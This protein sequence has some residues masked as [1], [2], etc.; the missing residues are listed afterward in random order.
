MSLDYDMHYP[1]MDGD[2]DYFTGKNSAETK[3]IKEVQARLGVKAD[4]LFGPDSLKALV[5]KLGLSSQYTLEAAQ[6]AF[7][8]IHVEVMKLEKPADKPKPSSSVWDWIKDHKVSLGI[9]AGV[10]IVG[11]FWM[12]RRGQKRLT[13]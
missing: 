12:R 11:T 9:G 5:A 6:E 13:S 4:G 10:L 3:K 1:T 8:K 7:D 2:N